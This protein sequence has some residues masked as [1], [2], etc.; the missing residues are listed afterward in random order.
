MNYGDYALIGSGLLVVIV[1]GIL[2]YV[3]VVRKKKDAPAEKKSTGGDDP[4]T[5]VRS[6]GSIAGSV[7]GSMPNPPLPK[8]CAGYSGQSENV[9]SSIE[10]KISQNKYAVDHQGVAAHKKLHSH[11]V[12]STNWPPAGACAPINEAPQMGLN[13]HEVVDGENT[14][15]LYTPVSYT[16]LTL[17]TKA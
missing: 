6:G 17:P 8:V 3:Y 2:Y 12:Q 5:M 11:N 16:H 15:R 14:M 9:L 13:Q 4:E 10:R 7:G 1:L